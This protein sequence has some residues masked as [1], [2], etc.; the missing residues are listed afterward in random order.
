MANSL[1]EIRIEIEPFFEEEIQHYSLSYFCESHKEIDVVSED[2]HEIDVYELSSLWYKRFSGGYWS[3]VLYTWPWA[4]IPDLFGALAEEWAWGEIL[5]HAVIEG[6][7]LLFSHKADSAVSAFL[8]THA[9]DCNVISNVE[10]LF[11][12]ALR[13]LAN[14]DE[15]YR[16]IYAE[17]Y[18]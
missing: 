14:Q 2:I 13:H 4:N 18:D 11:S 3:G 15:S 9:K 17:G 10:T 16:I 8:R 12:L 7:V 6:D 5:K 1:K